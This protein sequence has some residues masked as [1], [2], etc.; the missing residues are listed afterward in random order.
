MQE[1]ARTLN[2]SYLL[3]KAVGNTHTL[4][5]MSGPEFIL[6]IWYDLVATFAFAIT[7]AIIGLQ[8]KYDIVGV[9]ALA[10]AVGVG[11]GTIRDGIFLQTPPA[12]ATDWRYMAAILTAVVAAIGLFHVLHNKALRLTVD[13]LDA[14]GL[15]AY[16]IVGTQKATLAG[17]VVFGAVLVGVIN[18]VGGGVLRDILSGVEPRIY[19]PSQWY[20]IISVGGS[21]LFL[22]LAGLASLGMQVSAI[23][24]IATMVIIRAIVIVFDI[25]TRPAES[26]RNIVRGKKQP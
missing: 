19:R 1:Q 8:K 12:I 6:P 18:A 21:L 3:P 10:I 26:V 23:I 14:L 4:Y 17:F 20:A 7:G 5:S 9:V 24:A 25:K 11:G 2:I 13:M 16:T 15:A 22:A